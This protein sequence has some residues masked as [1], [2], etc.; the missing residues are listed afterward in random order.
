MHTLLKPAFNTFSKGSI[1]VKNEQKKQKD[2]FDLLL[3]SCLSKR[4]FQPELN[5][6]S[7]AAAGYL[8][9]VRIGQT[10]IACIGDGRI[11]IAEI[12]VV[13][14]IQEVGAELKPLSLCE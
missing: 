7:A 10:A 14:G 3:T 11:R 9:G 12:E 8:A 6:A 2:I 5:D 13:K 4:I 1:K